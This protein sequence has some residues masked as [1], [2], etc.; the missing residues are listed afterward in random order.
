[1]KNKEFNASLDSV[2]ILS[3]NTH[4]YT[5]TYALGIK[6]NDGVFA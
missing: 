1:M 5:Y 4:I 2:A 3:L 6:L